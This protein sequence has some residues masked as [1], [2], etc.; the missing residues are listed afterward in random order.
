MLR[1]AQSFTNPTSQTTTGSVTGP[2]NYGG[3][4]SQIG[5]DLASM[6]MLRKMFGNAGGSGGGGGF[7]DGFTGQV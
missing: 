2:S 5:G 1:L 3:A 4:F 7:D 6:L